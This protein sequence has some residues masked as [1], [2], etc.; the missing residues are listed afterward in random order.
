MSKDNFDDDEL[1]KQ[2]RE[3]ETG[4]ELEETNGE[5]GEEDLDDLDKEFEEMEAE[6][7]REEN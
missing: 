1:E 6:L 4:H 5:E 3:L 7:M 2:F